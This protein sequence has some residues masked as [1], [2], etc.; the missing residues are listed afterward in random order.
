MN[1]LNKIYIFKNFIHKIFQM[2]ENQ[3][4]KKINEIKG[5]KGSNHFNNNILNDKM[6]R[7]IVMIILI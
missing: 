3:Q 1:K 7:I 4:N 6:N 5:L 2:E